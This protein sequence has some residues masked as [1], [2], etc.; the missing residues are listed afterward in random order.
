MYYLKQN[1][2]AKKYNTKTFYEKG[3]VIISIKDVILNQDSFKKREKIFNN[4]G[5]WVDTKPLVY[6]SKDNIVN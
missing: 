3:S 6:K 1:I 2:S 4:E 5:L